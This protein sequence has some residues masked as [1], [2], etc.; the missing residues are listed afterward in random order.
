MYDEYTLECTYIYDKK[1]NFTLQYRNCRIDYK[2][3]TLKKNVRT[4]S[5][6]NVQ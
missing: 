4:Y 2:M 5:T 1:N 3:S 6:W